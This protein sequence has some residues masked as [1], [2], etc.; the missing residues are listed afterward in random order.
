MG[1]TYIQSMRYV[2]LPQA[3]RA[4]TP[5]LLTQAIILFQDTSLVYVV[6][7]RDFLV[8]AEIVA[9]RDQRL[10]EMFLFVALVYFVFCFAASLGFKYLQKRINNEL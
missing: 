8:S 10:V 5:I 3:F 1:L 2:I 4:M 7:L 9:N 6:G